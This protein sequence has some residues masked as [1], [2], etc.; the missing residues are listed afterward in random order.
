MTYNFKT[1]LKAGQR[2]EAFLDTL[3]SRDFQ[4]KSASITQQR[5]G[6]DR[7]LRHYQTGQIWKAE[8]KSDQTART[9][10]N[11]FVETVSVDSKL[12]LGWA[13]T[14]EADLL[15][16][17]IPG[18]ELVY[19]IRFDQLRAML[20]QWLPKYPARSVANQGYSTHGILVPLAE[21][22]KLAQDVI[23]C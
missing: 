5:Q 18:D 20:P 7:I 11:A 15:F 8:Y 13:I 2:S 17:Y 21:F 10:G 23:S 12:K 1:Q 22:E 6:I 4:I 9:T 16:Y 3:L 14:S 19:I